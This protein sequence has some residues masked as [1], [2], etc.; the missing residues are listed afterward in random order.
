M[1][2]WKWEN[3]GAAEELHVQEE[4]ELGR[5]RQEVIQPN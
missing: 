3:R 2:Q 4:A 5:I 1:A